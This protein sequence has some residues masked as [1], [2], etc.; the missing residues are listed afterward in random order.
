MKRIEKAKNNFLE[1]KEIKKR[2]T[3]IKPAKK[4]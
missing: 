3:E 2:S 4:Q 1:I